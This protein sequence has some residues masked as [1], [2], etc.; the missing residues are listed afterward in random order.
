MKSSN[1]KKQIK[2]HHTKPLHASHKDFAAHLSKEM[3]A[4]FKRRSIEVRKGDTVRVMRGD[5]KVNGK[6]GKVSSIMRAKKMVLVEGIISKKTDGTERL[7]PL[8]PSNLLV[9]ALDEKDSRR[10]GKAKK[11][12]K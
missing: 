3:R 12:E 1:P 2:W 8:R 6:Q 11:G 7:I 4:Q 10:F 9:I 5:S